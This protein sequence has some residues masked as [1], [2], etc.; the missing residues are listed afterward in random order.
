M[1]RSASGGTNRRLH[2]QWAGLTVPAPGSCA[3]GD[4]YDVVGRPDGTVAVVFGDVMGHGDDVASTAGFLNRV[5]RGV[6]SEGHGPELVLRSAREQATRLGTTATVFYGVADLPTGELGFCSAGHP[7]PVLLH[8]QWRARLPVV[9]TPPL[10]SGWTCGHDWSSV[11]LLP[12]ET[13]V[14]YSDGLADASGTFSERT[15]DAVA[16]AAAAGANPHQLCSA[17]LDAA[18]PCGDDRTVLVLRLSDGL[19]LDL[20][21]HAWSARF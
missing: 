7:P 8:P 20:R 18:E 13:L 17:A 6:A 11:L 4:W 1:P 14:I 12:G 10:G 15:A 2:L 5:V 16:V 9:P 3:G 19:A 21:G